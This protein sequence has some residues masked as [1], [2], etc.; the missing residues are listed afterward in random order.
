MDSLTQQ[1]IN[2]FL[3]TWQERPEY[4]S[5]L[6]TGSFAIGTVRPESDIDLRILYR[7]GTDYCEV[8]ECLINN[9]CVSFLAM[10]AVDYEE[11]F[12][13]DLQTGSKFE[14]LAV[15]VGQILDDPNGQM[16]VLQQQASHFA[17][18][19][20]EGYLP[21][22][23]LQE[24]LKLNRQFKLLLEMSQEDL[25]FPLAYFE[26]LQGILK[27]YAKFIQADIP[28]FVKKWNR[29]FTQAN[30]RAASQ[31]TT[32]PDEQFVSLFL[33]AV[34]SIQLEALEKLHHY[35]I[36]ET[37]GLP[38]TNFMARFYSN[39]NKAELFSIQ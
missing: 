12:K 16:A 22:D 19:S 1:T 27:F 8:G 28:A 10:S 26:L 3:D 34:Q 35:I 11:C 9:K 2:S 13:M 6:I 31:L 4:D 38:D 20:I 14:I 33:E 7:E 32:F 37:E 18:K 24:K 5:A 23:L 29:F 15:V 36:E 39:K 21:V 30:Y 17:A 25:F